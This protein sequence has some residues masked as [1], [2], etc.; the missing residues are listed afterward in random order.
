MRHRLRIG[1]GKEI[2]NEGDEIGTTRGSRQ[3]SS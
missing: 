1:I 2:E 3:A